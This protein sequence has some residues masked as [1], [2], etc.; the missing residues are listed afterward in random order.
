MTSGLK[1][2]F[3]T[4]PETTWRI[5]QEGFDP[6]QEHD[7]ESLFTIGN[8]YLGVR[9]SSEPLGRFSRPAMFVA[10][11]FSPEPR[12]QMPQL[13]VCPFPFSVKLCIDGHC[14]DPEPHVPEEHRRILDLKRGLMLRE[15]VLDDGDGKR[16]ALRA[17]RGASLDNRN[18]LF[19]YFEIEPLNYTGEVEVQF[20]IP[21]SANNMGGVSHLTLE[22]ASPLPG[23]GTVSRFKTKNDE[24]LAIASISQPW[25]S[26]ELD[27]GHTSEGGDGSSDATE[28]WRWRAEQGETYGFTRIVGVSTGRMSDSP[29]DQVILDSQEW[30]SRPM[31]DV[32]GGQ[33][34]SWELLWR[35][36]DVKIKGDDFYQQALRFYLYHMLI[37]ANPDDPEVSIGARTLSGEGYNGHVFW[38]TETFMFPFFVATQP[39]MARALIKYRHLTLDGARRKAKDL[40]FE[41]AYYPWESALTGDEVTPKEVYVEDENRTIP[42]HTGFLQTHITADV[43]LAV[44]RYW[45]ATGDDAFMREGGLEILLETARVWKS[46]S[47]EGPDECFHI[48][49]L[50]G[51]DEY[52]IY[53]NDNAYTNYMASWNVLR[54]LETLEWMRDNYPSDA[55]TILAGCEMDQEEIEGLQDY[56]TRIYFP[57]DPDAPAIEQFRGFFELDSRT[58][59]EHGRKDGPLS[60]AMEPDLLQKT[61]ILKQPDILLLFQLFPE[62]A[63]KK[64]FRKNFEYYEPRCDHGS[65]LSYPTHALLAARLGKYDM[66]MNYLGLTARLD[67]D[68][69]M[70]NAALGIHAATAGGLWQAIVFGFGGLQYEEE[71]DSIVV[72]PRLPDHWE[73]LEFC[74]FDH[75]E[76]F[77]ITITN[78]PVSWEIRTRVNKNGET[79]KIRSSSP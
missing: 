12:L 39:E 2:L 34:D 35:D 22:E 6:Y 55:E 45:H 37:S 62:L 1:E 44:R 42:I 59:Q 48:E 60:Q 69:V 40:G 74:A 11:L 29:R 56:A 18:V 24:E 49:D 79:R 30:L 71:S 32:I 53:V 46:R 66:A 63:C 27:V 54:A 13:V 14:L 51:P 38:D 3:S 68:D 20:M 5:D 50:Q 41:G 65:S 19:Q 77:E 52:H 58:V 67:L 72:D 15:W 17:V 75:G 25:F 64:G 73:S 7:I 70:G 8:G 31:A 57:D 33:I 78:N 21:G 61:Q 9:G 43:A 47:V 16:T 26:D 36:S 28:S 10:G 23:K 4:A 76:I